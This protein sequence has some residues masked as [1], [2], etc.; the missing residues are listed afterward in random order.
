M[1]KPIHGLDLDFLGRVRTYNK[2]ALGLKSVHMG[3]VR[4]NLLVFPC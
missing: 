1:Q 4:M 3:T 2:D